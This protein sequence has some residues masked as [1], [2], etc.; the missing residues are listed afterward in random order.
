MQIRDR[1]YVGGRWI[2]PS[3]GETI[4][5]VN[6][7]SEA[8]IAR[9]PAANEVDANAA[10]ESAR[11]ALEAWGD[12]PL[13]ERLNLLE[14]LLEAL[15][16]RSE[17][18]AQTIS[19]EVGMP[20]KLSRKI[21]AGLPSA[22]LESTLGVARG[23][24]FEET[25]GHSLVWREP[26]GVVACITPWNYPL[27]Q[28]MAKIAPAL[29]AGCTVVLKPSEL[30]PL[31]TFILAEAVES[32]GFPPGVFN[33]VTG[34][35][36]VV[37]EALA[38]HPGVDMVSFTGST[39]AGRRVIELA[40]RTVKRTAL[41]LGGKSAAVVLQDADLP[42][43]VKGTIASCFL[44]SGQ[45]CSAHTRLLVPSSLHEEAAALAAEAA[46]L[47]TPGDPLDPATRLGPLVSFAQRERVLNYIRKGI[48]EGARLASGGLERPADPE[49]GYFVQPTVFAAVRPEM[50]IARE[51]IFGPVLCIL[52]YDNEEEAVA[53]A[54]GT[55][56]GLA[57]GVWSG[58]QERATRLAR[59]LKAGQVDI[60][61]A[62][63]NILAPFGGVRQSGY[64]RE[65][66]RYGLE[67]FLVTKSV[68]IERR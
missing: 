17:E 18:I 65:F 63:F 35:G 54:N 52:P 1:L 32:A 26:V 13:F 57:A 23:F 41:E 33:L 48:N 56:Y 38:S 4:E 2:T 64:G 6:P 34:Y 50:V 46:A 15:S 53:M 68:Q 20:L 25:V 45:T 30:A 27:H 8:V 55:P 49:R 44:N 47:Y 12:L 51:E 42:G 66:G 9:I 19:A 43:A 67:E 28:A 21:Q 61:G 60:N 10:V 36:P 62:R 22:V 11:A 40:S 59:R 7:A 16:A 24:P 29:A 37:G 39:A 58:D 14:R 5:V 3:G 31:S